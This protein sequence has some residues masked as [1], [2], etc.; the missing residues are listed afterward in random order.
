MVRK[1]I[2][3]PCGLVVKFDIHNLMQ[4]LVNNLHNADVIECCKLKVRNWLFLG[5]RFSYIGNDVYSVMVLKQVGRLVEL[6][7]RSLRSNDQY[8]TPF[9]NL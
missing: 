5:C 8:F 9:R 1:V 4:I 3:L 7:L 6:L 2:V